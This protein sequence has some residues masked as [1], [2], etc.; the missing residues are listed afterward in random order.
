MLI[1]KLGCYVNTVVVPVVDL[2]HASEVFLLPLQNQHLDVSCALWPDIGHIWRHPVASL[3]SL[4]LSHFKL[5]PPH[6]VDSS[7]MISTYPPAFPS[8]R[9]SHDK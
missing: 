7:S 2:S 8:W 3:A 6:S 4:L 5:H 1:L 9:L